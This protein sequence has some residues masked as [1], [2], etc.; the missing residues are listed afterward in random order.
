MKKET[1]YKLFAVGL[2][3]LFLIEMAAIG[4]LTG[5]RGGEGEGSRNGNLS[6]AFGA[7]E[8]NLT[9]LRYEPYLLVS[10]SQEQ[11][12]Q[13]KKRLTEKKFATYSTKMNEFTV[14]SLN[15]SRDVVAAAE[16]IE[17]LNLTVLA[18]A[19]LALPEM[20]KV[21]S[22]SGV[23]DAKGS[24]FQMQLKPIYPEGA[25]I[26]A[27]LVARVERGQVVA[28]GSLIFLPQVL[29]AEVDGKIE[30]VKENFWIA[31]IPWESRNLAKQIAKQEEVAFKERSYLLVKNASSE[32]LAQV[33]NFEYVTAVQED[34]ISI[35]NDFADRQK[36]MAD[37][38][39]INLEP[40]FPYSSAQFQRGENET[41]FEHA[42]KQQNI[43]FQLKKKTKAEIL[44]PGKIR[45]GEE[46]YI[47]TKSKIELEIEAEDAEEIRLWLQ[48]EAAGNRVQRIIQVQPAEEEKQSA[49]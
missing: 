11:I 47:N 28:I 13:A 29:T 22:E 33:R 17:D 32:Q 10:G 44:L 49:S 18:T 30:K 20:V 8:G 1:L 25:K 19:T 23:V 6:S 43:T 34:T 9:V 5:G 15:R 2:V 36:A 48:F 37:F 24:T 45:V 14:I 16:E 41:G 42:L 21:R 4:L 31:E 26:S 39:A 27:S 46:E 35:R 12:E 3:A 7:V 38:Y 40:I